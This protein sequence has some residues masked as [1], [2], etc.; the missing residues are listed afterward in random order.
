MAPAATPVPE[1][2]MGTLVG[3]SSRWAA[4]SRRPVVSS[5]RQSY[6]AAGTEWI[7][8]P[9][10]FFFGVLVLCRPSKRRYEMTRDTADYFIMCQGLR[11][12]RNKAAARSSGKVSWGSSDNYRQSIAGASTSVLSQLRTC[13]VAY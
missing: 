2:G 4:P 1:G 3:S 8:L 5:S 11:R 10:M 7:L 12:R 13:Y 9:D 6:A